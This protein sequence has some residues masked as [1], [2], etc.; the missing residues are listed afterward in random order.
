MSWQNFKF[1]R[2]IFQSLCFFGLEELEVLWTEFDILSTEL[3]ILLKNLR[4]LLWGPGFMLFWRNIIFTHSFSLS[5]LQLL[6]NLWNLLF[7]NFTNCL[8]YQAP[9]GRIKYL[10]TNQYIF[11]DSVNVSMYLF[12]EGL[13]PSVKGDAIYV[14][15]D[16]WPW[17]FSFRVIAGVH[18][19]LIIDSE[20]WD[21]S[22][23][24]ENHGLQI[25]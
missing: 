1:R 6:V 24:V 15:V 21:W 11:L 3:Q 9:F 4:V 25:I 10:P 20:V 19:S 14:H 5:Q 16:I 17:S 23:L 7:L 13:A 22:Y 18:L 8:E 12:S 2:Q